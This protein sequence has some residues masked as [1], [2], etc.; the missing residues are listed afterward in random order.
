MAMNFP[1]P[2]ESPWT[3][4]NGRVW[5]HD[6]DGWEQSC[7]AEGGG[8]SD[9]YA[10]T[11]PDVN[12]Y[13]E[14][15]GWVR[16]TDMVKFQLYVDP[17]SRQ[18]VEVSSS[19]QG[20]TT[21]LKNIVINGAFIVNQRSFNG[22]WGA[23]GVGAFGYDR[24]QKYSGS[25]IQ[26]PVEY[27]TLLG[28]TTYTL[29]WS[30]GTGDGILRDG[31][32]N[33]LASGPSPLTAVIPSPSGNTAACY[34]VVPNDS[35]FVQLERGSV[36]TNYELRALALEVTLCKRFFNRWDSG[37]RNIKFTLYTANGD[38]RAQWM[39]FQTP[40]RVAPTVVNGQWTSTGILGIGL[41]TNYVNAP[42]NTWR[43]NATNQG[44]YISAVTYSGYS[45]TVVAGS[46]RMDMVG[47]YVDFDAEL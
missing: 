3:D 33:T 25:Q 47:G 5:V 38:T 2:S 36:V 46:I 10:E 7:E 42:S 17:D 11:A 18:W 20:I 34:V 45:D 16:T 15:Q 44:F 29:S 21:G 1:P 14:G 28:G 23:L 26:Q 19:A 9:I 43:I 4:P 24:W 27:N 40:M 13:D 37:S 41:T 30:G 6:G 39:Y 12:N 32:G 8:P 22:D 35:S 31:D